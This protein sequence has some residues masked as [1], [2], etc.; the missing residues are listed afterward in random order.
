MLTPA[1]KLNLPES[2]MN[3]ISDETGIRV[4]DRFR[5]RYVRLTPEELVRQQL[6]NYLTDHLGYPVSLTKVESS[7]KYNGM[8]KRADAI[9]YKGAEPVM[10]IECKA[11]SV[12]VSQSTFD[13]IARYNFSMRVGY[14]LV[15]NGLKHYCC[16]MDYQQNTYRILTQIPFYEEL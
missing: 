2:P 4:F 1:E 8:E 15:S 6:L 16:R 5:K 12:A 10:V 9:I 7:L 11:T 13:Q 3:L 14:L